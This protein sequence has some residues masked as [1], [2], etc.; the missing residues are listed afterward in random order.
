MRDSAALADSEIW[1]GLTGVALWG[2]GRCGGFPGLG[3]GL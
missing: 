3:L 1:V 2:A